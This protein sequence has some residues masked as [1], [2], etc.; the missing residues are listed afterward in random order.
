[1]RRRP[2]FRRYP[3]RAPVPCQ[4]QRDRLP[5]GPASHIRVASE[6]LWRSQRLT[7]RGP[8]RRRPPAATVSRAGRC[9]RDSVASQRPRQRGRHPGRGRPVATE[10]PPGSQCHSKTVTGPA[11]GSAASEL[12]GRGGRLQVTGYR[13]TVAAQPAGGRLSL[14]L[15]RSDGPPPARAALRTEPEPLSP[16]R[17]PGPS[18]VGRIT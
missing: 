1:M 8:R 16:E 13:D 18:R 12:L 5:G 4:P 7:G 3:V 17:P 11:C 9:S 15:S 6:S 2:R 10:A 14:I